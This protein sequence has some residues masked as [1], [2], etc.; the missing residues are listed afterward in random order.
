MANDPL[1]LDNSFVGALLGWD[2]FNPINLYHYDIYNGE[3]PEM[4]R[5]L[6]SVLL[7]NP[8]YR[9]QYNAHLRTIID[10]SLDVIAIENEAF[11]IQG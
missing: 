1:D 3:D 10:E 5:P 11:E 7:S 2:Y 8:L 4:N 6:L 9:K